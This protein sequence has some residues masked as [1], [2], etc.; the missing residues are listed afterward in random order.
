[1]RILVFAVV[2]LCGQAHLVWAQSD[3]AIRGQ[4]V[5]TAD[6]SPIS[7]AHVTL[8]STATAFARQTSADASGR[9]LFQLLSPGQYLLATTAE[10]FAAR[11]TPLVVEPRE[12]KTVTVSL[13]LR[14]VEASVEVTAEAARISSTRSPSS[15]VFSSTALEALPAS[16]HQNLPEAVVVAAPGMIRGH[17]DFV[18]VRGHEVALN[19]MINGVSFWENPHSLFSAGLSPD[20][21]ESA[22]LMTGGF[23]AEYGNRFGGVLDIVTKSGLRMQN[24]GSVTATGG[25]AG[26]RSAAGDFGGHRERLG[27]YL[28]ASVFESDRF[29]SPPAPEAIH[30]SGRGARG[31]FQLDGDLGNPG[32]VRLVLTGD[33]ANFEIPKHP[34]DLDLRPGEGAAQR[35]RQQ[36]AILGWTRAWSTTAMSTSFYQRWSRSQLMPALAPLTAFA[37][38]DRELLTVGAKIDVMRFA[39]RHALKG[40]L[41]AV[42]LRPTEQLSYDYSGFRAF[43]HLLGWPHIHF[44]DV[45]NFTGSGS[46]GQLSAYLQDE[47]RLGNWLSADLGVRVD[48]HDLVVSATHVSPRVNLAMNAGGGT[49]VH[50]SYNH[51]FVPPPVEGVL[52]SNADLTARIGEIGIALP[53]IRPTTEDQFEIGASRDVGPLRLAL[54]G[55]FRATDNPVH[56]TVWPDSR[57]YSYASFDRARAYGLEAKADIARLTRFG[58]TG[59]LNYAL[60]RVNFHNPVTGGFTTEA[61]HIGDTSA[62]LAPMDQTHTATAGATYR[63]A[64]SGVWA[65]TTIEYGSG[66]PMGHGGTDHDHAESE[67]DHEHAAAAGGRSR[68]PAHATANLSF[69]VDLLRSNVARGRLSLRLDVENVTNRVYL[70]AQEGEFSP[71]Q[72]S[73]PRL[74]AVTVKVRF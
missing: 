47:I 49:T 67:A 19:P 72:Y 65:G 66:T 1:M 26:R 74:V 38:L 40:G 3:A 24:D 30:D 2:I 16:Q 22:S 58:V 39:G 33:G 37:D 27:Y 70:V 31:F 17:D 4:I 7:G 59:Y 43:T 54:A 13:D 42:R 5:A 10:G 29:L 68:V 12:L 73:V 14:R 35:T 56:T 20:V 8:K 52:S 60:G 46:G 63:H 6:G 28:F 48:R 71:A 21:I 45:M 62:F 36:S 53:V 57:I 41:D 32:S 9:F 51:F 69:G 25:Q 18:H 11:E 64:T 23:P 15:T 34:R 61:A 50:A 44:T 55:Y